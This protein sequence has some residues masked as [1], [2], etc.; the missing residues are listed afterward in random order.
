MCVAYVKA[1]DQ[2]LEEGLSVQY[3]ADNVGA[4]EVAR[5]CRQEAG[6]P[7]A[8]EPLFQLPKGYGSV[9]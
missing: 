4:G 5:S 8:G 9:I 6:G 7:R 3:G 1:C 2:L